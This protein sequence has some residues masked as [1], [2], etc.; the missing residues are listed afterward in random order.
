MTLSTPSK[1]GWPNTSSTPGR[2]PTAGSAVSGHDVPAKAKAL[3]RR[4]AGGPAS[5][6]R[7]AS[8]SDRPVRRG[9]QSDPGR[10][11]LLR[12]CPD[13]DAVSSGGA[14]A[15]WAHRDVRRGRSWSTVYSA[16]QAVLGRVGQHPDNARL[17]APDVHR[18]PV[19]L[20]NLR[21]GL[22]RRTG[23]HAHAGGHSNARTRTGG[24]SDALADGAGYADRHASSGDGGDA[25]VYHDSDADSNVNACATG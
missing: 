11:F 8:G 23:C 25:H 5:G 17:L 10:K 20:L 18:L 1:G 13:G 15:W 24:Y 7:P 21:S 12:G 22:D 6:A 14:G 2:Q 4:V 3:G 19:Q 9:R 16:I